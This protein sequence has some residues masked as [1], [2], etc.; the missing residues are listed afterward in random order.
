MY[1][2]VLIHSPLLAHVGHI[3][4]KS[5]HINAAV[6]LKKNRNANLYSESN[7]LSIQG[8]ISAARTG[9]GGGGGARK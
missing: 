3:T 6:P 5:S 4:F 2:L 1:A 7:F 9:E 8:Q